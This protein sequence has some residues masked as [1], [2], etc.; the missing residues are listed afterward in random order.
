MFWHKHRTL[1]VNLIADSKMI[2]EIIV[3][4]IMHL[5]IHIISIQSYDIILLYHRSIFTFS[6]QKPNI[7]IPHAKIGKFIYTLFSK[8]QNTF[9][10][11]SRLWCFMFPSEV[12][13]IC[14]SITL[15]SFCF[16]D[17]PTPA[18]V[19]CSSDFSVTASLIFCNP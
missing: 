2:W 1:I 11:Y 5:W 9:F 17:F 18:D 4:S 15:S 12:A 19:L 10:F 8:F 13:W 6:S 16:S 14:T 7:Y 3:K